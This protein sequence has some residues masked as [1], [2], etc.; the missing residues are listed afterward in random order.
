MPRII[1]EIQA[2]E[3]DANVDPLLGATG[4][5][6]A[7]GGNDAAGGG[8]LDIG[9]DEDSKAE[10]DE[11]EQLITL[12]GEPLTPND[13]E[14]DEGAAPTW[15]KELRQI[16]R[17]QARRLREL[18]AA[19]AKSASQEPGKPAAIEVG[20]KPK[21]ED[22][23]YDT[24]KF[25]A[26][27]DAWYD[28]KRRA[29]EAEATQRKEQEAQ[30]SAWNETLTKHRERIAKLPFKDVAAVVAAVDA[31]LTTIQQGIIVQGAEDSGLLKYA[32]GKN[33]KRLAEMAALKDPVK[34]AFAVAKLENQLK[35]TSRSK[36]APTPEKPLGG[37]GRV[38][39]TESGDK[40]LERLRAEAEKT[41]DMTEVVRYRAKM[42]QRA[43]AGGT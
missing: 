28:R 18:E 20:K 14:G 33:P 2:G 40:Q 9:G 1:E 36:T 15:V 26:E 42:R 35:V 32:L 27:L 25:E 5:D 34:F 37:G 39:R 29:D 30:Q 12:N 22:F 23:D 41:G 43:A 10:G 3:G 8:D 38:A 4:G 31:E 19:A 21:V 24:D 17:E 16:N 11:G 7:D 13:E 6:N